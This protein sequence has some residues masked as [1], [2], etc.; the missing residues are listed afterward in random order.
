MT[1]D[2]AA[3]VATAFVALMTAVMITLTTTDIAASF[4]GA[5][6]LIVEVTDAIVVAIIDI[7]NVVITAPAVTSVATLREL[8]RRKCGKSPFPIPR[9]DGGIVRSKS[10]RGQ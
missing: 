3:A 5:V 9:C 7:W 2:F 6:H 8:S 1:A 4:I 10:G